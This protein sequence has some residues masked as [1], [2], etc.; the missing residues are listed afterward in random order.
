MFDV[1]LNYYFDA[2]N[3]INSAEFV[4]LWMT[5]DPK[6][7]K[8]TPHVYFWISEAR[9]GGRDPKFDWSRLFAPDTWLVDLKCSFGMV[10]LNNE[11]WYVQLVST[12]SNLIQLVSIWFNS[13]ESFL[14]FLFNEFQGMTTR[15]SRKRCCLG[16]HRHSALA[17]PCS[18]C[19]WQKISKEKKF[20]FCFAVCSIWFMFT[21]NWFG[22]F[23]LRVWKNLRHW[24]WINLQKKRKLQ[25]VRFL[26]VFGCS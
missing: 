26:R 8:A 18:C 3:I 6:P 1:F 20:T 9:T 11:I 14:Y 23:Q 22:C 21:S 24:R 7:P 16:P 5:S 4:H 2:V 17:S 15:P 19:Q 10:P 13:C 12:C 25:H